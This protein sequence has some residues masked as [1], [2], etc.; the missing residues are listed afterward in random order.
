MRSAPLINSLRQEF[1]FVLLSTS[2]TRLRQQG[3]KE[4]SWHNLHSV[5]GQISGQLDPPLSFFLTII[6]PT[7]TDGTSVYLLEV[8]TEV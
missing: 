8:I 3:V 5:V 1:Y 7:L 4:N 2:Q 6:V